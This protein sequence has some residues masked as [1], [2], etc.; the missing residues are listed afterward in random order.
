LAQDAGALALASEVDPAVLASVLALVLALVEG[1]LALVS[2]LALAPDV[3]VS[4][5][6][7]ALNEA[8]VA[9]AANT[10]ITVNDIVAKAEGMV[11]VVG[12]AAGKAAISIG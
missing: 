11:G 10:V 12:D 3:K 4:A 5:L 1:D 6:V 9:H 7:L 8:N 2:A